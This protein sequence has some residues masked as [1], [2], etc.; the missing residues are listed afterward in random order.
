MD[1]AAMRRARLID[2]GFFKAINVAIVTKKYPHLVGETLVSR[3]MS[4]VAPNRSAPKPSP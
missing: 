1:G 4:Q 2:G 3:S